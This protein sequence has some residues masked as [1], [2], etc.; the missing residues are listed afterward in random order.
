MSRGSLGQQ[1]PCVE[2]V[3]SWEHLL[4]QFPKMLFIQALLLRVQIALMLLLL[5]GWI[6]ICELSFL[7]NSIKAA[8]SEA[9]AAPHCEVYSAFGIN[10]PQTLLM[11]LLQW[12]WHFVGETGE[13]WALRVQCPC[14]GTASLISF[15]H[16][17]TTQTAVVQV[18]YVLP[19]GTQS[20]FVCPPSFVLAS[21]SKRKC[22]IL[23][24]RCYSCYQS[25]L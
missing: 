15:M 14:A 16:P 2:W 12:Q 7:L 19:K 13:S 20:T 21:S 6:S 8:L 24:L 22:S 23:I 5:Q 1:Q 17:Q 3:C 18:D 11:I 10:S 25:S 4:E 9:M